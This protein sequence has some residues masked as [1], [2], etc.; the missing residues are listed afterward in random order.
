M[1]PV[2]DLTYDHLLD[3]CNRRFGVRDVP[4]PFCGASKNNPSNRKRRVLRIWSK[5]GFVTYNCARCEKSGWARDNSSQ[6][7]TWQVPTAPNEVDPDNVQDQR[8]IE[9]A[10]WLWRRRKPIEG[11]PAEIYLRDVR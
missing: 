8:Q 11:S 4:C 1:I 2:C 6:S 9:K 7:N 5:P 3:L 10:R